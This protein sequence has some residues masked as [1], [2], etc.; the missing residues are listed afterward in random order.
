PM[1]DLD[2]LLDRAN[3]RGIFGTKMRS[4]INKASPTGIAA[5]VTQQFKVANQILDKDLMPIIEPEVSIKSADRADSDGILL[6]ELVRAL[7][8]QDRPV[9]LKLSIPATPDLF[10]PLVAHP[11]VARVVALSGGFSQD[12]ACAELARNH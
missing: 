4:V 12:E 9:M 7:D 10:A 5:I 3:A 11:K 6:E 8:A 2:A 1:P